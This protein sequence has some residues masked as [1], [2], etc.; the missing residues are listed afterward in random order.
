MYGVITNMVWLKECIVCNKESTGPG[1][2]F[3]AILGLR[4]Y[5]S[6]GPKCC[7]VTRKLATSDMIKQ[8]TF[9]YYK[10]LGQRKMKIIRS[11][12]DY[13]EADL[14]SRLGEKGP[15][16][17]RDNDLRVTVYFTD[18]DLNEYKK[19]VRYSTLGKINLHIPVIHL[20][21]LYENVSQHDK[22]HSDFELTKKKVF[23]ICLYNNRCSRIMIL[24]FV[25][26]DG[27]FSQLPITLFRKILNLY[28]DGIADD[29]N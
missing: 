1:E 21:R 14:E 8:Q 26:N 6:C 23:D 24:S 16:Y 13:Q 22:V 4:D 7:E 17:I 19:D 18:I 9:L 10:I 15:V 28:I 5:V 25:K 2:G 29:Q 3:S 11:S 12:G 20:T 27:F